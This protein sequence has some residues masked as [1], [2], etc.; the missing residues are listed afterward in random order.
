MILFLSKKVH[1]VHAWNICV[2]RKY[3]NTNRG[4]KGQVIQQDKLGL[5]LCWVL[6]ERLKEALPGVCLSRDGLMKKKN[7]FVGKNTTSLTSPG[8]SS[9]ILVDQSIAEATSQM[10]YTVRKV[11]VMTCKQSSADC[12]GVKEEVVLAL[13]GLHLQEQ[14][15]TPLAANM[16]HRN[17]MNHGS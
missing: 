5:E 8:Q 3:N 9:W 14:K 13:P 1:L 15:N 7:I 2:Q 12:A 4:I 17:Y 16:G 10:S 11:S 6:Q